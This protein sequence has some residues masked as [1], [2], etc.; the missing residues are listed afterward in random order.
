MRV[1]TMQMHT[2]KKSKPTLTPRIAQVLFKASFKVLYHS[3]HH[4]HSSCCWHR[5]MQGRAGDQIATWRPLS[6][7][8]VCMYVCMYVL[9]NGGQ[10]A[11]WRPLSL[12]YV[13]M[14][15]YMYVFVVQASFLASRYISMYI[16]VYY[17]LEIRSHDMASS[18]TCVCMYVCMYYVMEVRSHDMASSITCVCG[19]VCMYV[20]VVQASFLASRYILYGGRVIYVWINAICVC[21]CVLARKGVWIYVHM[22]VYLF[23]CVNVCAWMCVCMC[24]C[25]CECECER[26]CVCV[27]ECVCV[28]VCIWLCLLSEVWSVRVS[29]ILILMHMHIIIVDMYMA[30]KQTFIDGC[31]WMWRKVQTKLGTYANTGM[32]WRK[33]EKNNCIEAKQIH[34]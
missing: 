33:E 11:T 1:G 2:Y 24:E 12:V 6:P 19:Y 31:S 30:G 8:Y 32:S 4:Y 28:C 34:S 3:K 29:A 26:V 15:A 14:Y 7:V 23:M 27:C 25:E 13:G 10:I 9:C 18:V 5:D 21:V 17:V 22:R 16:C 20:C